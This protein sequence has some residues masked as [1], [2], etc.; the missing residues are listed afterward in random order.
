[1]NSRPLNSEEE[2]NLEVVRSAVGDFAL[3]FVTETGLRKSILDATLPLRTLLKEKGVHDF[4]NQRQGP[5]NKVVVPVRFVS[6]SKIADSRCSL[7]RP[8]TKHGD[9]RLWPYGLVEHCSP[10]DVFAVFC[11]EGKVHFLNLTVSNIDPNLG[12]YSIQEGI[13][14]VDTQTYSLGEALP[15]RDAATSILSSI[16][17]RFS[18]T[19]KSLLDKL[20]KIADCG[21]LES[22]C[23]GDTA[24]GRSIETALGISI[25][26]NKNPDFNGIE[27]KSYRS[28][29][30]RT[31]LITLFAKTPDWSRSYVKNSRDYL[32]VA[33][34]ERNGIKRLYCSV[35]ANNQNSQR[36]QL[37]LNQ[38]ANDL[39]EIYDNSPKKVIAVWAM[40]NL[41][42][43]F[44]RKH[45]ETFWISANTEL[46][47]GREH[48]RLKAVTHTQR[49]LVTQFDSLIVQGQICLDHTIKEKNG[50]VVDK[51]YLFRVRSARM[52]DLFAGKPRQ[53]DLL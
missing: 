6:N 29:K 18:T 37:N 44:R 21:P 8:I 25:N 24:I 15:S 43:E 10:N 4:N 7:Y 41:H 26:S 28:S 49:P 35:F 46:I 51:G 42:A 22:V 3:L 27:I 32:A 45:N 33:G 52:P 16:Q 19:A 5:D 1:M 13:E 30:P 48:F 47:A 14:G 23:T 34:Y 40:D 20:R 11:H 17:G 2:Q 9:P 36:L 38:T 39:E 31:G 12:S 50:R 53:Y